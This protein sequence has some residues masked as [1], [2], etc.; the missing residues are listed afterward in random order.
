MNYK[1]SFVLVVLLCL[2]IVL[3]M[4]EE[5]SQDISGKYIKEMQMDSNMTN[6]ENNITKVLTKEINSPMKAT[7]Q[8]NERTRIPKEYTVPLVNETRSKQVWSELVSLNFSSSR[9]DTLL[10]I[11][12]KEKMGEILYEDIA[13]KLNEGTL[14]DKITTTLIKILTDAYEGG[15]FGD[16]TYFFPKNK[17]DGVIQSA[18]RQQLM[19]PRGKQSLMITMDLL[20]YLEGGNQTDILENTIETHSNLLS[21]TER[22][23]YR[24][25]YASNNYDI[26]SNIINSLDSNIDSYNMVIFEKL[27]GSLLLQKNKLLNN[28]KLQDSMLDY[29]ENNVVD[30]TNINV[31]PFDEKTSKSEE[32]ASWLWAYGAATGEENLDAYFYQQ[33]LAETNVLKLLAIIEFQKNRGTML[34]TFEEVDMLVNNIQIQEVLGNSMIDS[35]LDV[36]TKRQISS[37]IGNIPINDMQEPLELSEAIFTMSEKQKNDVKKNLTQML[38]NPDLTEGEKFEIQDMLKYNF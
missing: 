32:Y 35:K 31:L 21:E 37:I 3:S 26:I 25:H 5:T 7:E 9:A 38:K 16:N 22:L 27:N 36:E 19:N 17:K 4:R 13:L 14:S 10:D 29:L 28:K 18:M 23:Q 6:T 8:L 12:R 20:Y 24:L 2:I 11:L 1:L 15:N 30:M 33:A 34:G